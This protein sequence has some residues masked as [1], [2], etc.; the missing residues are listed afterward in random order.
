MGGVSFLVPLFSPDGSSVSVSGISLVGNLAHG[1]TGT[2][3]GDALGG[4]IAVVGDDAA[5]IGD[6]AIDLQLGRG[7]L[8]LRRRR[9][10]QRLRRRHLCRQRLECC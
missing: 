10:R 4:G 3:G 5:T 6:S 2:S 8:R 9:R 7:R 1:G